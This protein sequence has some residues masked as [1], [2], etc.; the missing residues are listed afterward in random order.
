[1]FA[2]VGFQQEAVLYDRDKR[3]AG[4][5]HYTLKKM[6]K[7][8]GDGIFSFSVKPLKAIAGL[9]LLL[10]AAAGITL[11]TLLI[12]LFCGVPGGLWWLAMLMT[13]LTGCVLAA[14][15]VLGEYVARIYDEARKRPLYIVAEAIGFPQDEC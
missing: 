9:G 15:G 1:M 6:L 10:L 12:L 3:Y 5:T 11:L 2:W 7:L 13:G 4:E 14:L 8:A